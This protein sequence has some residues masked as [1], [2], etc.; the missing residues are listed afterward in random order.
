MNDSLILNHVAIP[1]RN[2]ED[3][4]AFYEA[5]GFTRGFER[6]VQGRTTLL[7]MRQGPTF[8]ELIVSGEAPSGHFGLASQ[9]MER[10]LVE[11][12]AAGIV[13]DAAPR[14]GETGVLF[15]F[16]TDPAGNLVEITAP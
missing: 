1:T 5:L 15:A 10:T 9:D 2:M 13:P 6:R 8:I 12:K 16:F 14:R 3:S 4:A 7:Q 11:M